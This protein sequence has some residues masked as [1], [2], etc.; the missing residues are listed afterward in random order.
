MQ[1][2]TL[3]DEES[4][5]AGCRA[6]ADSLEKKFS[7]I[8]KHLPSLSKMR[9][10]DLLKLIQD[11]GWK[12]PDQG[13]TVVQLKEFLKE[14]DSAMDIGSTKMEFGQYKGIYT[15][16]DVIE[17]DPDYC[18]WSL[19]TN[20]P[21]ARAKEFNRYLESRGMTGQS[22]PTS[23]STGERPQRAPGQFQSSA[24]PAGGNHT[25]Q[26]KDTSST[27]QRKRDA[28][29]E[30]WT[31]M[32]TTWSSTTITETPSQFEYAASLTELLNR[33]LAQ[34]DE[35][36]QASRTLRQ[37]T[38]M[39]R[40]QWMEANTGNTNPEDMKNWMKKDAKLATIGR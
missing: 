31:S 30:E 8:M 12:V 28:G 38:Q 25:R 27:H 39:V 22:W 17:E 15:F 16:D 9:K 34:I 10:A 24:P 40:E 6:S 23:G 11:N 5:E 14:K 35:H 21:S 1:R 4:F 18:F 13:M 26:G 29:E 2:D 19:S 7:K 33:V 3:T 20:R 32:D 37:T 36:P